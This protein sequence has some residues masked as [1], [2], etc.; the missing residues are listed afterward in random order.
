MLTTIQP[1]EV[2]FVRVTY[3]RGPEWS[4]FTS[5]PG[6]VAAKA[7]GLRIIIPWSQISSVELF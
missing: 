3:L 6:V 2:S 5:E 1:I 7:S 4:M